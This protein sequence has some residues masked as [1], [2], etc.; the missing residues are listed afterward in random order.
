MQRQ[1][2]NLKQ[3]LIK[4]VN[5]DGL[6]GKITDKFMGFLRENSN[7]MYQGQDMGV[8]SQN[9]SLSFMDE[10]KVEVDPGMRER[11]QT[12]AIT[13]KNL[14]EK[15]EIENKQDKGTTVQANRIDTYKINNQ[16]SVYYIKPG[17]KEV[18]LLDLKKRAFTKEEL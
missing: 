6:K 16:N 15:M 14:Q 2:K 3:A 17:G 11:R 1:A 8:P 13:L 12:V 5:T 10:E 4:T 18:Y 7:K 9:V